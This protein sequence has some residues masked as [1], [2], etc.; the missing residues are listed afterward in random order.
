VLDRIFTQYSVQKLNQAAGRI[1][2][3]LGKL[4]EEQVWAR[5]NSNE[6]AVGNLVLHVC[7]NIRQWIISGVGASPDSRD[8]DA[9][10]A[11]TGGVS[12]LELQSRLAAT[13]AEGCS[14]IRSLSA[15]RLET[16]ISV[17]SHDLTVLEAVYH[18]I[19]HFSGHT[20]QIIFA[21][22]MLTGEDLGFYKGLKASAQS[23]RS[24]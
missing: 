21:T 10:F 2:S 3:C 16:Q 23:A 12:I 1:D 20:G 14:V 15:Q 18:V 6:N 19:E 17:Q 11:A 24:Q 7:G 4:T 22:K 9:E 13:V 8:R 5:G